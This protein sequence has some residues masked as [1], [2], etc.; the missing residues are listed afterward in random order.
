M[1]SGERRW[2]GLFIVTKRMTDTITMPI[3]AGHQTKKAV[4]I[5]RVATAID[6]AIRTPLPRSSEPTA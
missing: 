5:D 1:R 3:A 6:W 4:M 2:T